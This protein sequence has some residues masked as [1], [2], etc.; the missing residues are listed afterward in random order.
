MEDIREKEIDTER[1][2]Q[3]EIDTNRKDITPTELEQNYGSS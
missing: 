2:R 1:T 3:N